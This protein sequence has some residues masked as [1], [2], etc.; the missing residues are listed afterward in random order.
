[1]PSESI[2]VNPPSPLEIL[3]AVRGIVWIFSGIAQC[4]SQQ[5]QLGGG[6]P[7]YYKHGPQLRYFHRKIEEK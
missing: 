4:I 1:M 3:K 5:F 2:I 7:S 6:D